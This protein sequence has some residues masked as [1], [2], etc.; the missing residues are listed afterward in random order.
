ME[1]KV[2]TYLATRTGLPYLAMSTQFRTIG[3]FEELRDR[4]VCRVNDNKIQRQL[5][6]VTNT[7]LDFKKALKLALSMEAAEKNAHELQNRA[8]T[9]AGISPLRSQTDL[10]RVDM[11]HGLLSVWETWTQVRPVPIQDRPLS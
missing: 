7:K 10:N 5:L 1:H 2:T 8:G 11:P 6:G 4:L 9:G 3:E